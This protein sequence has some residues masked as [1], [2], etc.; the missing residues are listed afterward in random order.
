MGKIPVRLIFFKWVETTNWLRCWV[1]AKRKSFCTVSER[2][3]TSDFD[4]SQNVEHIKHHRC[5]ENQIHGGSNNLYSYTHQSHQVCTILVEEVK[6]QTSEVSRVD[7]FPWKQ[8][9]HTSYFYREFSGFGSITPPKTNMTMGNPPF[10]DIFPS[11]NGDFPMSC[12]F[13][14]V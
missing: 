8:V 11:E 13:S 10:A 2:E 12:Q 4:P 9:H 7:P 3:Q 5:V 14:G 1:V 6:K